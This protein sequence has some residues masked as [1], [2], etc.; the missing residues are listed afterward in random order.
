MEEKYYNIFSGYEEYLA[1]RKDKYNRIMSYSISGHDYSRPIVSEIL[2]R[3]GFAP[4]YP[5]GKKFG[6][7]LSHDIDLLYLTNSF[8]KVI[9]NIMKGMYAKDK[10]L[11]SHSLISLLRNKIWDEYAVNHLLDIESKYG[12]KSTFFFFG[13]NGNEIGY[14]YQISEQKELL[15]NIQNAGCEIGLHGSYE[16]YS[17]EKKLRVEKQNLEEALGSEVIGYRN[18]NLNF[19]IS[20]T[21]ALLEKVG[22]KY[23]ATYGLADRVGF[24]NGMCHPFYPYDRASNNTIGLVA[25][26]LHLMDT[27]ILHYMNMSLDQGFREL[28]KIVG[29]VKNCNG[30]ISFLWHNESDIERLRFYNK[31]L[32]YLQAE[33]AWFGTASELYTHYQEQGYFSAM[34]GLLKLDK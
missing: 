7:V 11:L 26:P 6:V 2:H 32:H 18:H 16:A 17:D 14:N 31:C 9:V 4:T 23:D 13:V 29:A 21:W 10:R 27:T 24:R 25:I 20:R 15:V 22:F 34:H 1:T 12:A 5:G 28:N 19:D 30:V 33:G 8:T 3:S